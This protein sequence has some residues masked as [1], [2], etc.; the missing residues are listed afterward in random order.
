[1]C[2]QS[3]LNLSILI[4][5]VALVLGCC[6]RP[7]YCVAQLFNFLSQ[8]SENK[9]ISN[10][11]IDVLKNVFILI[12][13]TSS[14]SLYREF[15][16]TLKSLHGAK[17]LSANYK[18]IIKAVIISAHSHVI[19]LFSINIIED[20]SQVTSVQEHQWLNRNWLNSIFVNFVCASQ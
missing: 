2:I 12:F 5:T 15:C 4:L 17:T 16:N 19:S 1:M 20:A 18:C 3:C 10:F 13:S 9:R 6:I 14:H 7:S 11:Y 8:I